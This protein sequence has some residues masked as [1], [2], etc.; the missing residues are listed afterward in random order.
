MIAQFFR[1]FIVCLIVAV[2]ATAVHDA[3]AKTREEVRAIQK[4]RKAKLRA[5]RHK[6]EALTQMCRQSCDVKCGEPR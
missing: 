6:R 4:A 3:S 5:E 1:D 2:L